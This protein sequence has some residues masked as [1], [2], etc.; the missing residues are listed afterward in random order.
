M[1]IKYVSLFSGCG[2]FDLGIESTG[3][4]E[5][6][7]SVELEKKYYNTL[8]SNK[9]GIFFNDVQFLE[10]AS[11]INDDV[12]S[13]AVLK[14]I[15][16]ISINEKLWG[17]VAGPPCQSFSTLGKKGGLADPR[18][19]LTIKFFEL[20]TLYKPSF[21]IFEN[22]PPLGQNPGKEVRSIISNLLVNAGY[23]F[24]SKIVNMADYGCYTKRKRYII[25]GSRIGF[26]PFPKETHSDSGDLYLEKWRTSRDALAGLPDPYL[27]N[28]YSHHEP[29][30]HTDEVKFRFS[31]LL[32]GQYD[33][34]R[35]RSKLNPDSP[36]PTLISGAGEGHRNHIHWDSRELSSRES[37]RLH[38][39]PDNFTF[40]GTRPNVSKQIANSVPIEFGAAI[41]SHIATWLKK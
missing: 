33:K 9:G 40:Y 19:N 22:V 16:D 29:V 36:G 3:H 8:L 12:F 13:D 11:I 10:L 25:L 2:G 37:A 31:K 41:G 38:G 20:I 21:F 5:C 18:G 15:N 35:H 30:H 17:V 34:V 1:K 26:I 4:Y 28:N 27:N 24:E 7:L 39:F 6:L 32:P 23:T 14:N